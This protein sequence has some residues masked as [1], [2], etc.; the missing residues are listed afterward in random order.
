MINKNISDFCRNIQHLVLRDVVP[1]SVKMNNLSN[2]VSAIT[3]GNS[4]LYK[5]TI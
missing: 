3:Y 2:I 5:F 1:G 4:T